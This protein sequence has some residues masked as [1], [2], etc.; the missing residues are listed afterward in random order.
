MRLS[1]NMKEGGKGVKLSPTTKKTILKK[2]SLIRVNVK[3]VCIEPF[4][5]HLDLQN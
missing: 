5:F 1:S 3:S 4:R 2:P